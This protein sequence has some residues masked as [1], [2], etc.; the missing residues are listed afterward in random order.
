VSDELKIPADLKIWEVE[1]E[2]TLL[3]PVVA[4]T[5]EEAEDIAD[6]HIDD[7]LQNQGTSSSFCYAHEIKG[8]QTEHKDSIPW[9][10]ERFDG[11][12]E[13][14]VGRLLALGREGRPPDVL[15][16]QETLPGM[17]TAK[18]IEV[19]RK[20]AEP[21]KETSQAD[22]P[23]KCGCGLPLPVAV[24]DEKAAKDLDVSEIRKRWPRLSHKCVCGVT[25]IIYASHMHYSMGDW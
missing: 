3:I 25:T 15:P 13:M 19:A 10:L 8:P 20:L 9:G 12:G 11:I 23:M 24:F 17:M 2:I 6:E 14:T 18:E 16:G 22:L 7:E 1:V 4:R 21:P 5:E